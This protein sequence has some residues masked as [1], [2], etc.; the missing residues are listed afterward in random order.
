[1]CF[2]YRALLS[3][4]LQLARI[5]TDSV[6]EMLRELHPDLHFEIGRWCGFF[7]FCSGVDCSRSQPVIFVQDVRTEYC[8]EEDDLPR[9]LRVQSEFI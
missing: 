8:Q 2:L 5:Q 1:M 9:Y 6:V 4:L 3:A 7:C